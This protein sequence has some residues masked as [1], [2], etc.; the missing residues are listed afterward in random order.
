M[1]IPVLFCSQ[2]L[3]QELTRSAV[4]QAASVQL[5]KKVKIAVYGESNR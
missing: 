4:E 3:H 1:Y 5:L 2:R